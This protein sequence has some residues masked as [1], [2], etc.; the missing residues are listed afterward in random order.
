ME[1]ASGSDSGVQ[2]WKQ[3]QEL[4]QLSPEM[5]T[6]EFHEVLDKVGVDRNGTG[7][8]RVLRFPKNTFY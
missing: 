7:L 3:Q 1:T 4:Q 6:A 5:E 8:C 2:E